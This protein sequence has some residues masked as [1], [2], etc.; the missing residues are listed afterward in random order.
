MSAHN[1]HRSRHP[2]PAARDE[3][4]DR[5]LVE[6]RTEFLRYFRRRLASPEEAEE[7]LQD[8]SLKVIRAAPPP[9]DEKIGAWLG[10]MLNDTVTDHH[11][12]RATR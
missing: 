8:F 9:E 2:N 6:C 4:V 1:R 3:A 5:H 10:R 11:R 7:V 12:R